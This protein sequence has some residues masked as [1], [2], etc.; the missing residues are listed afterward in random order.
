MQVKRV[1]PICNTVFYVDESRLKHGRGKY[2]SPECQYQGRTPKE[3]I[4]CTC[5]VCGK[6]FARYKSQIKS[7][8]VFCSRACAYEGRSLGFVKRTIVKPYDCY[9]KPKRICLVC[10]AEFVYHKATHKYCSRKCFEIAHKDRMLGDRNPAYI[11]GRSKDKR[12]YR[13]DD[14]EQIRLQVY[15]RDNYK[16]QVCGH[17]CK[18]KEIQAHHIIKYR[19]TQ[20]NSLDNLVTLCVKCHPNVE[21]NPEILYEKRPDLRPNTKIPYKLDVGSTESS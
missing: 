10:G 21:Y 15:K 8:Y 14:W 6:R 5:P 1:C 17:H 7:E 20:D 13:G 16:C 4:E 2:C 12:S 18:R 19:E 3:K 9:R 11:D